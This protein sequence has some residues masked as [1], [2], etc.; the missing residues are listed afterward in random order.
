MQITIVVL[1]VKSSDGVARCE[2]RGFLPS[3]QILIEGRALEGHDPV[4][5][6]RAARELKEWLA[7]HRPGLS[8]VVDDTVVHATPYAFPGAGLERY[9]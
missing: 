6:S 3:G 9:V 7:A 8:V 2:A 4:T 1:N 5:R